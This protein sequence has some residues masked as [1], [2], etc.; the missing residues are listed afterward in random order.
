MFY[1]EVMGAYGVMSVGLILSVLGFVVY[2][3]KKGKKPE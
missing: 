1:A 3:D 2:V